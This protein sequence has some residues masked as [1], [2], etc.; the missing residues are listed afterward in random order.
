MATPSTLPS[1]S[2]RITSFQLSAP[3]SSGTI[4][5]SASRRNTPMLVAP[6]VRLLKGQGFGWG[7]MGRIR[8]GCMFYFFFPSPSCD[9][10]TDRVCVFRNYESTGA[11]TLDN[12]KPTNPT[13]QVCECV[14]EGVLAT[15]S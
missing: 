2:S 15:L 10:S 11:C 9:P 5:G 8:L 1:G 6:V 13:A 12:G 14:Y 3:G 4:P 7:R